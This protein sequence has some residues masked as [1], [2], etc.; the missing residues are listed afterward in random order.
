MI[1]PAGRG[2]PKTMRDLPR[3][4]LLWNDEE[5]APSGCQILML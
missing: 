4:D 3:I 5:R 2:T 1:L